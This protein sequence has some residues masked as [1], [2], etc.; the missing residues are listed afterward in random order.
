MRICFKNFQKW[1][2][3]VTLP[4]NPPSAI[5]LKQTFA[6][7]S[8]WTQFMARVTGGRP[9][10]QR[11][12]DPKSRPIKASQSFKKWA[13]PCL[14]FVYFRLFKNITILEQI[15]EKTCPSS[16]RCWDSKPQPLDHESPPVTTRPGLP[17]KHHKVLKISF[18]VFVES[19]Y[20]SIPRKIK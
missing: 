2:N 9:L 8:K 3:L 18:W 7:V 14:F 10:E 6:F 19:L 15:N 11:K 17:P 16:I 20:S 4:K 12:S 1:P 5:I 13:I